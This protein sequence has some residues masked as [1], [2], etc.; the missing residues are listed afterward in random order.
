MEMVPDWLGNERIDDMKCCNH[1]CNQG[2][3][4]PNRNNPVKTATGLQI[5]A[6]A[7]FTGLVV[8]N[9]M[10]A[11]YFLG[12]WIVDGIVMLAETVK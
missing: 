9:V 12:S 3:D 1:D 6:M 8:A 2:R 10:M 5:V 11:A 7:C 4:C